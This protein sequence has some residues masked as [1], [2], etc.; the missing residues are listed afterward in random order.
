M[1]THDFCPLTHSWQPEV[2]GGLTLHGVLVNALP[3]ITDAQAKVPF[4]VSDLHSDPPRLRVT[5]GV[6]QRFA[7]DPIC[8]VPHDRIQTPRRAF[9][10]EI[11]DR[12]FA[13]S[14]V[15][16][17]FFCKGSYCV[18]KIIGFEG[19][20]AQPLHSVT[21]FGNRLS[22]LL[23]RVIKPLPGFVWTLG[24]EFRSRLEP[25]Q[26]ALKTLKQSVV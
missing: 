7:G 12:R 2:S 25:E 21:T 18:G 16:R 5:E 6:A 17:E 20:R 13:R 9:Y 11:N 24:Q 23:N 26:Q 3:V 15:L 8:L 4:V 22:R 10:F 14:A 1:S 19:R